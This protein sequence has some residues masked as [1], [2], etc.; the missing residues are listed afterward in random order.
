M[1]RN[2]RVDYEDDLL[3]TGSV[4]SFS[5]ADKLVATKDD[6]TE[7]DTIKGK[8]QSIKHLLDI[9]FL[10]KLPISSD[11]NENL[12][13]VESFGAKL[14]SDNSHIEDAISEHIDAL[15]ASGGDPPAGL[16]NVFNTEDKEEFREPPKFKKRLKSSYRRPK[17]T[18]APS[19]SEPEATPQPLIIIC[20]D[21]NY[22]PPPTPSYRYPPYKRPGYAGPGLTV[23]RDPTKCKPHNPYR[24]KAKV[25]GS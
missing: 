15:D 21:P 1:S 2:D 4:V 6:L 13:E 17:T 20:E 24:I 3:Q 5:K 12:K 22:C 18:E 11:M 23:C 7:S 19:Y 8:T 10:L 25:T 14:N 16:E 9:A